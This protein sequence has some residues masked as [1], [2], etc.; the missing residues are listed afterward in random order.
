MWS[1]FVADLNT[2]CTKSCLK[3]EGPRIVY[4]NYD[5]SLRAFSLP[6][7]WAVG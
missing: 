6:S 5:L 2:K 7:M 1:T 4:E 3:I